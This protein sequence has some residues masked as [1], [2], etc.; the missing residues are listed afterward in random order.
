MDVWIPAMT[1]NVCPDCKNHMSTI[2]DMCPNCGRVT[3][4]LAV[5]IVIRAIFFA[6]IILVL[7][8]S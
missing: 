4:S 1:L 2:A 7:V 6:V 3:E 8:F 5:N